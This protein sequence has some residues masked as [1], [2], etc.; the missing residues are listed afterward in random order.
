VN[1][2]ILILIFNFKNFNIT[3]SI[4]LYFIM[5]Y[6]KSLCIDVAVIEP[7]QEKWCSK[8]GCPEISKNSNKIAEK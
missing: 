7:L 8:S 5:D 2:S 3:H 6:G 1:D 4:T